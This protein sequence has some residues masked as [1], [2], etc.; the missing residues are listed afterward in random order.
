MAGWISGVAV[1]LLGLVGVASGDA[2]AQDAPSPVLADTELA[3]LVALLD[4]A[5]DGL[6]ARL[7]G[8]TDEQWRFKPGPDRWSVAECVEH[9]ARGEAALLESIEQ[10]LEM[11]PDPEWHSKTS[12]KLALV[13]RYVPNRGPQGQGG[14]QAPEEIR[15]TEGW[16]RSR[17]IARFYATHGR[18]RAFVETMRRD[19]KDR[20]HESPVFSWLNAYARLFS[21]G[22]HIV[23]HTR[24]I[25]E[26]QADPDYPAKPDA[27]S[28]PEPDPRV[29]DD[30]LA[31]LVRAIDEAQDF[32]LGRISGLTDEQWTFKESPSRWSVAECVEHIA[33]TERAVLDGIVYALSAPPNPSWF[34][35]T[36]GKIDLVRQAVLDRP[37]GGVG[38]PFRATYEVSPWKAGTARMRCGSSTA[39]TASCARWSRACRG[40]SRTAPS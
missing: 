40:R 23:R 25:A 17:G 33:R 34:E 37:A 18:A 30:E 16:S 1:L 15:P 36:R 12:G 26:V 13:Q 21:L 31:E 4:S 29:T 24:Q 11:S 28:A 32:L 19:I 9:I 8:L 39:P 20:T 14:V 3:E 7:T 5:Q 27:P 22:L 2:S 35:Q 38:S 6:L 10:M